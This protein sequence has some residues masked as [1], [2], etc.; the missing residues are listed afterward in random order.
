MQTF[1]FDVDHEHNKKNNELFK[2]TKRL[3]ISAGSYGAVQ[4]LLAAGVYWW[5]GGATWAAIL[6]VVLIAMAL[7]SFALIRIIPK[8]VGDAE[9]IYSQYPLAPAVIAQV[10]PRD[11]V[12]FALVNKNTDPDL[13]PRWALTARTVTRLEG[14][15]RRKGERVPAVAVSGRRSLATKDQ[16]DEITPMPIAWATPSAKTVA[17]AI[18]HIP[19][20]QWR[21]LTANIGKLDDVLASRYNLIEL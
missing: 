5:A 13:S 17:E 19:E 7:V 20:E 21:R 16:W 8:K 6:A 11:I 4:I 14:H 12:L 3:Q 9:K 10:N 1:T 15:P 18:D 2:D